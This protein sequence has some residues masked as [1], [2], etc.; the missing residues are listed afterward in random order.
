MVASEVAVYVRVFGSPIS[1]TSRSN[2]GISN[3]NYNEDTNVVVF[4]VLFHS[5]CF[6][7]IDYIKI[8][9]RTHI[10]ISKYETFKLH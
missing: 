8:S 2:S 5:T 3:N 7:I 4:L 1:T 10:T 9:C 6:E